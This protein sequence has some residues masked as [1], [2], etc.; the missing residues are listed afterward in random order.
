MSSRVK[1]K[2]SKKEN[3]AENTS[4][5]FSN[6]NVIMKKK[7]NDEFHDFLE[8]FFAGFDCEKSIRDHVVKPI[9]SMV[10][11]ELFPYVVFFSSILI[12]CIFLLLLVAFILVFSR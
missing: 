6:L 10:Y 8:E 7:N 11:H 5:F 3:F 2:F 1:K 12:L 9:I 4:S